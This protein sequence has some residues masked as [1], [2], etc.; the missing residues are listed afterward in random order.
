MSTTNI[1]K[2]YARGLKLLT[3]N[4][5]LPS[6]CRD[7]RFFLKLFNENNN[8]ISNILNNPAFSTQDKK[9]IVHKILNNHIYISNNI[10]CSFICLLIKKKRLNFANEIFQILKQDM[11]DTL[12]IVN[13]EIISFELINKNFLNNIVKILTNILNRKINIKFI[14]CKSLFGGMQIKIGNYLLDDSI[15]NKLFNLEKKL[16]DINV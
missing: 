1:A 10:L 7:Y 8:N 15:K 3:K 16:I 14:Q 2:R 12:N 13:V 9:N 6:I 11:E 5:E 4:E